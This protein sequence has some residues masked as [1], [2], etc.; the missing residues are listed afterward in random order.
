MTPPPNSPTMVRSTTSL[1]HSPYRRF[2]H[3]EA[4]PFDERD[5]LAVASASV[6]LRSPTTGGVWR[7][8]DDVRQW[9]SG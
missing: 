5:D 3:P 4:E 2:G 7:T 6:C 1:A 8:Q 9:M